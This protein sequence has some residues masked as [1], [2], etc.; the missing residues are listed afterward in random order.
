MQREQNRQLLHDH[1]FTIWLTAS[2]A[3]LAVRIQADPTT[4]A[5]RPNLAM[6][7][8][9]EIENL[10]RIREPLYRRCADLTVD[11]E[12]QSPEA[13]VETIL[14]AWNPLSGFGS[15]S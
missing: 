3:T 15:P 10:M 2:V 4:T 13:I 11:T 8:T 14:N 6:G 1:G 5:R 12:G 7:G 9:Q